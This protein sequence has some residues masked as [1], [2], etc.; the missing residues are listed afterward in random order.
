MW[1]PL[2]VIKFLKGWAGSGVGDNTSSSA[3]RGRAKRTISK[4]EVNLVYIPGSN[5][6]RI[7]GLCLEKIKTNSFK[8]KVAEKNIIV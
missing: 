6:A 8:L 1:I 5:Q 4:L 3:G 2:K 7:H